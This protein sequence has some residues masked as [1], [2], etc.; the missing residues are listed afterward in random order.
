MKVMSRTPSKRKFTINRNH[1]KGK[2]RIIEDGQKCHRP[3]HCR[4]LCSK[5]HSLM[6]RRDLIDKYGSKLK[7]VFF[8]ESEYAI[9]KQINKKQCRIIENG[10]IC[11][12]GLH[13]R[14]LCARHWL[15]F[16]RHDVLEKYGGESR[17][18]PKTYAIKKRIVEGICRLT[19]DGKPCK[20]DIKNR[21]ICSKHYSRFLRNG[22]LNKYGKKRK[23]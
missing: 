19:V 18:G 14:G 9:R 8:D 6:L 5:H 4:D 16:D 21:G 20:K 22:Q 2:C 7:Y 10:K 15:C 1:K 11:K 3:T 17:M 13:G 23:T 12:G